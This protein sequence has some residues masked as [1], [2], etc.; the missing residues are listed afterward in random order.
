MGIVSA[1]RIPSSRRLP[2]PST[3]LSAASSSVDASRLVEVARTTIQTPSQG[4]HPALPP[5]PSRREERWHPLPRS[6][7]SGRI[8]VC[9]GATSNGRVERAIPLPA[10]PHGRA[11]RIEARRYDGSRASTRQS[12]GGAG[13]APFSDPQLKPRLSNQLPVHRPANQTR[14]ASASQM[15]SRDFSRGSRETREPPNPD[16]RA[17]PPP[18]PFPPSRRPSNDHLFIDSREASPCDCPPATRSA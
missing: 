7:A 6:P 9:A 11:A 2:K 10:A 14:A 3:S 17:P 16:A 1:R 18:Q 4:D 12:R 5:T 8:L 15:P 13:A